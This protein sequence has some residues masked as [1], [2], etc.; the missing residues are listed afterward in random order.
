MFINVLNVHNNVLDSYYVDLR[1][2]DP[3]LTR[4]RRPVDKAEH[5]VPHGQGSDLNVTL[6]TLQFHMGD[7]WTKK[8]N[9]DKLQ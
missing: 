3:P 7:T 2:L 1:H 5:V 9:Y 4:Y 6:H 8:S